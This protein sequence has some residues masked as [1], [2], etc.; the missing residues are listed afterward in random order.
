MIRPFQLSPVFVALIAACGGGSASTFAG[1]AP[2]RPTGIGAIGT[3]GLVAAY[4]MSTRTE[5]GRLA[6]LSGN[7]LHGE[8]SSF[9]WVEG[10]FGLAADLSNVE[11]RIHLPEGPAFDLDGPLTIA[12]WVRVDAGGLHQH[13]VACDDKWALWVT[14]DDRYRLGDTRGGGWSTAPHAVRPGRW[15]SVVAVLD[16][17]QGEVYFIAAKVGAVFEQSGSGPF[18]AFIASVNSTVY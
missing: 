9:E 3:D 18:R 7:G 14:P 6:D 4:D 10:K 1:I 12:T 2:E 15:T 17:T 16:V 5:D 11:R 13:I 8:A